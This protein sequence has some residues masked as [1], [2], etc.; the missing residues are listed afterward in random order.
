VILLGTGADRR[1]AAALA[2][3]LDHWML[4]EQFG[5][6]DLAAAGG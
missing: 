2:A 1:Q 3:H 5:I 4:V 6:A